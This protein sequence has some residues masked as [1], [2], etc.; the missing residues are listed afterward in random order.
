[1]SFL[2][3]ADSS[4][5]LPKSPAFTRSPFTIQLPRERRITL[6]YETETVMISINPELFSRLL[7]NLVSNAYRYGRENGHIRVPLWQEDSSLVLSVAD[8]GIGLAHNEQE[9]IFRRFYQADASRGGEST[10]LGL[11][12]SGLLPPFTN[13]FLIIA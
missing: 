9:K 7:V 4:L 12:F 2:A 6:E 8:D 13:I 10:G 1:M 11:A 5:I 3:S